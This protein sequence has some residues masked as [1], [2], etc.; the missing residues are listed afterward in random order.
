MDAALEC[1]SGPGAEGDAAGLV[2]GAEDPAFFDEVGDEVF[3]LVGVVLSEWAFGD[4]G[5]EGFDVADVVERQ[6]AVEHVGM[7]VAGSVIG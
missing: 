2:A 1:G 4:V 5:A 3:L 6:G 7:V